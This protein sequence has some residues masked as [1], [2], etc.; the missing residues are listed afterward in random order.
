MPG[1]GD[2]APLDAARGQAVGL[3]EFASALDSEALESGGH[4]GLATLFA[5]S[6]PALRS[7]ALDPSSASAEGLAQAHRL[8]AESDVLIVA[9]RNAHLYPAQCDAARL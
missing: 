3:V 6:L 4:T 8:A 2:W 5:A 7:V 9:T 1:E